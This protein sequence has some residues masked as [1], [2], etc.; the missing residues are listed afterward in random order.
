MVK[1]IVMFRLNG[2]PE[3]RAALGAEFKVAIEALPQTI[4]QL[5]AVE[6][7]LN[8]G[9]AAGNWDIV[10]TALCADY[11]ALEA[12]AGHP[13]HLACVAIIKPAIAARAC[14]DYIA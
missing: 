14:V 7:G 9:P 5:D 4:E 2:T 3:E 11:A 13:A 6:V 12:Y 8:D 10:L 1:H